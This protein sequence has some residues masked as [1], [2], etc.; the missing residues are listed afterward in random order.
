DGG[1]MGV[2]CTGPAR[3]SRSGQGGASPAGA[4]ASNRATRSS[5]TASSPSPPVALPPAPVPGTSPSAT[6]FSRG[7]DPPQAPASV[8]ALRGPMAQAAIVSVRTVLTK[9]VRTTAAGYHQIGR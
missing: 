9:P 3:S 6:V 7:D 8:S 5:Q 4:G 2:T 1:T